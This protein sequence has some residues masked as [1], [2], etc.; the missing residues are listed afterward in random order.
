MILHVPF[1]VMQQIIHY[2][3]AA[4]PNEVT[5]IGTIKQTTPSDFLVTGIILPHQRTNPGYS[6]FDDGELN[7]IITDLLTD[8]PERAVGLRFRWH[9]HGRGQTFWSSTD[10]AD[11]AK[12]QAPWAVNLVVNALGESSARFDMFNPFSIV[13]YPMKVAIDYCYESEL[14]AMCYQE[15]A[16]KVKPL[17]VSMDRAIDPRKIFQEGK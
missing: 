8:E 15:V 14:K 7:N 11:I 17:P 3:N 9:S 5:G 1:L 12:W 16:E 13:N 10:N 2:T 6:E 4:L